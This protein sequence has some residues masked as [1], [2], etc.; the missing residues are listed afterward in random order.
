MIRLLVSLKIMNEKRD[1]FLEVVNSLVGESRKEEGCVE[2][3][4]LET[5]L[6]NFFYIIELWKDEESLEKHNETEH[7]KK[8][9]PMLDSFK[10]SPMVMEKYTK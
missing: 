8:Y 10:E 5:D 2:Y 9:V 1:E 7:F 4:C 3:S 6:K